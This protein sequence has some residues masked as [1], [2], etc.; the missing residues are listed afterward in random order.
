MKLLVGVVYVDVSDSASYN[1]GSTDI[2]IVDT[3]GAHSNSMLC[4]LYYGYTWHES[5]LLFL[6]LL[7]MPFKVLSC[8]SVLSSAFSISF[9]PWTIIC[10]YKTPVLMTCQYLF[11]K[12]FL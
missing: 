7:E 10:L 9:D 8:Q 2:Q 5:A 4:S 1:L 12:K 6:A 11:P 3:C